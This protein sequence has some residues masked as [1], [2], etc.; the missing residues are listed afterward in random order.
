MRLLVASI[1]FFA[2][3]SCA[4][5]Q[6]SNPEAAA[7]KLQPG[8]YV[9]VNN[10]WIPMQQITMSGGGAKHVGKMFV[11][12]LTPQMVW[13]FRDSK[14]PMQIETSSPRFCFKFIAIPA[15]T[16]YAPSGRDIAIVWVD[17]RWPRAYGAT[18]SRL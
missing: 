8:A 15:G 7:S 4:I 2:I 3:A 11:P 13:T 14:A 5:A 18:R 9:W 1:L 10:S 12:G 17:I 6:T 16:P